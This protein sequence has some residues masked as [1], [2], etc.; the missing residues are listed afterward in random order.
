[1]VE[2]K[3]HRPRFA[4][5]L[6]AEIRQR[7]HKLVAIT[8]RNL[9]L[10]LSY[11][12]RAHGC[13]EL[14]KLVR[15]IS[16]KLSSWL[17]SCVTVR[18]RVRRRKLSENPASS[19]DGEETAGR[20]ESKAGWMWAW[21]SCPTRTISSRQTRGDRLQGNT[22]NLCEHTRESSMLREQYESQTYPLEHLHHDL[23]RGILAERDR[24]LRPI[25]C[26][27]R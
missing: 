4:V 2:C 20:G 26:A 27:S 25:Q 21:I 15:S 10:P 13:L 6:R 3:S 12:R 9:S 1:M 23:H 11:G 5:G 24:D 22:H 14:A 16:P 7:P 17:D 18:S 19:T 8:T